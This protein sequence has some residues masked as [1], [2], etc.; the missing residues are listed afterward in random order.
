MERGLYLRGVMDLLG[1]SE[2]AINKLVNDGHIS[3]N[4]IGT[5]GKRVFNKNTVQEFKSSPIYRSLKKQSI[6]VYLCCTTKEQEETVRRKVEQYCKQNNFKANIISQLDRGR[7]EI[8]QESY[9][10]AINYIF[11]S[12]GISGLIYF[13]DT[14]DVLQ[15][16]KIFQLREG[17]FVYGAQEIELKTSLL[18]NEDIEKLSFEYT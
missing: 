2:S 13:G 7:Q 6:F 5:N 8:T 4:R 15:L 14:D 16:K 11:D 3:F 10:M 12:S 9:K 17:T 18:V 1:L